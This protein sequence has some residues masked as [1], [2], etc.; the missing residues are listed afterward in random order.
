M[1]DETVGYVADPSHLDRFL[2]RIVKNG[3]RTPFR[4][5]DM[6]RVLDFDN[7]PDP[8]TGGA[9]MYCE[10]G[11]AEG[12]KFTVR[13]MVLRGGFLFYYDVQDV[14][15]EEGDV[16]YLDEPLG[17]LP[18]NKVG[19]EFPPGGR[20]V[21]REHAHTDARNG[22]ELVVYHAP[23]DSDNAETRPPAF[24]VLESLAQREKWCAALKARAEIDQETKLRI[25]FETRFQDDREHGAPTPV[26][27]KSRGMVRQ[28]AAFYMAPSPTKKG[29]S[30]RG[31]L[32]EL[33]SDDL[34]ATRATEEF[35]RPDFSD[36]IWVDDFFRNN[37]DFDAPTK[38]RLLENWQASIKRG[39]KDSVLEQYEYFVDASSE[40]TKMGR[41]VAA[42]KSMVETQNECIKEMKEIDFTAGFGSMLAVYDSDDEGIEPPH[43][44]AGA[45]RARRGQASRL[46]DAQSDASS[47]SS[48]DDRGIE[49]KETFDP[50]GIENYI[51]IPPE[52]DDICEE[53]SA[54]IKES[55]YTDATDLLLKAKQDVD[56]LFALVRCVAACIVCY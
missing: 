33:E 1:S 44:Q 52:L 56:E 32:L 38:C 53:I 37:L 48:G 2:P 27:M 51:E 43:L 47:M 16:E 5:G 23:D 10:D 29:K 18:L 8:P 15:E 14:Y 40:M 4:K 21:F 6:K 28:S 39:L 11:G 31:A 54:F 22:Y 35:G 50:F 9:V 17:V 42:L 46:D 12:L 25:V 19:V 55:R 7:V 34:D 24:L 41:E 20:R 3:E 13:H 30:K 26:K 45:L 36:E 49:S